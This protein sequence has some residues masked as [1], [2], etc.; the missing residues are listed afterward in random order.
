MTGPL[1]EYWN[2][3]KRG[4]SELNFLLNIFQTVIMV[5]AAGT[6]ADIFG[7]IITFSI[8]FA[9]VLAAGSL[10]VGKYSLTR[11]DTSIAFINPF[12]QDMVVFRGQLALGLEYLA[13]GDTARAQTAFSEAQDITDRWTKK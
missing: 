2:Y 4:K 10:M 12:A 9:V 5:W 13:I 7:D 3:F 6:V 8:I 11:V 1:R